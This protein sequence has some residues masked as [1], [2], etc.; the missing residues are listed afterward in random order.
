[1]TTIT[2]P[3]RHLAD[4]FAT[5]GAFARHSVALV[6][7]AATLLFLSTGPHTAAAA[8]SWTLPVWLLIGAD[9]I[10]PS[11]RRKPPVHLPS[12]PFDRLLDLL[13]ALQI[14]NIA[15][16]VQMVAQLG[17]TSPGEIVRAACNLLAIRI[18]VGTTSCCSGIAVAHELIHRR[19]AFA[20]LFGRI[21]L[22]TVCYEHFAVE[23]LR[24]HHRNVGT[25]DDPATAR[26]GETYSAYWR[27]TKFEQFR[28]AWSLENARLGLIGALPLS[29]RMLRHEVLLG[30]I[31][32]GVLLVLITLYGGIAAAVI[33][34]LQALAAI[35]LLEAVNYFQHW[36]LTRRGQRGQSLDAWATDSWITRHVFIGLARH[37]DHHRHGTK[38]YQLL[39]HCDQGPELPCGYFGMAL[40]AKSF[41]RRFQKTAL[42]EL[43]RYRMRTAQCA[44]ITNICSPAI[45]DRSLEPRACLEHRAC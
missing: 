11:D 34:L 9:I 16:M 20:R 32:Q 21:V 38:P 15:L 2:E 22:C 13:A 17:W 10:S 27:R 4:R 30:A 29:W 24:G 8:L 31:A 45:A 36:G 7:P 28:S 23:H 44:D 42:T 6:L 5:I 12:W 1:M 40:L 26:L 37:A 43:R 41:N 39:E 18:L 25:R 14:L 19:G 33:F 35:R 3:R